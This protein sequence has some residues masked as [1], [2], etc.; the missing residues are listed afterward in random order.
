MKKINEL[1]K[2]YSI[3][4]YRYTKE[5]KVTIID[6]DDNRYVIKEKA[7]NNLKIYNYLASRNFNYYPKILNS[8]NDDYQIMEYI[9]E[10]D[11]PDEQKMMD[12]IDLVSLLHS[13]TTH[14]KET[15][16]DDYKEIYEDITNNIIYL[17]ENLSKNKVILP[18]KKAKYVYEFPINTISKYN[19]KLNDKIKVTE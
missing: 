6:T 17:K 2:E 9:D 1:L 16:E 12:L 8:N 10:Y 15:D 5:G 13:K 7:S 11:I 4:P 19:L 18:I 3:K 14:F